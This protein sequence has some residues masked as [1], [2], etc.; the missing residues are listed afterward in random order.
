[1]TANVGNNDRLI[2]TVLG[3]LILGAGLYYESY[4]GLIGLIPLATAVLRWCPA[5][6]PFHLSTADKKQAPASK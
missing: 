1:M 6:L 3:F 5:Y 2:R 4:W